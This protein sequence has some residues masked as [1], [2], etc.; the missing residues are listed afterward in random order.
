M[1]KQTMAICIGI[2]HIRTLSTE[3]RTGAA[4]TEYLRKVSLGHHQAG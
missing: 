3:L 1:F 2:D 4:R